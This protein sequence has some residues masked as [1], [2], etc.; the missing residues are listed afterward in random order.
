M[1][2]IY[3]HPL[4]QARKEL[5]L[6]Q[7]DVAIATFLSVSTIKRAEKNEPLDDDVVTRICKYISE[8]YHHEITPE[9]LGLKRRSKS[10]INVSPRQQKEKKDAYN[11]PSESE[12]KGKK[13]TL[14]EHNG[15]GNISMDRRTALQTLSAL[16]FTIVASPFDLLHSQP[17]KELIAAP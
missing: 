1:N 16:G 12:T 15:E 4:R 8:E 9:E 13:E 7:E 17:V 5:N 6:S 14:E 3:I 10:K 2:A 11:T